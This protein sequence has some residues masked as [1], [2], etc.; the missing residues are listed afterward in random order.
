VAS[1]RKT[2]VTACVIE[3]CDGESWVGGLCAAHHQRQVRHGDPLRGGPVR[4][5]VSG[6]CEAEGCERPKYAKGFCSMHYQRA[7][8]GMAL[9]A[10]RKAQPG[11]GHVGRDGYRYIFRPGHPNASVNGKIAEHRYVMAEHLG[12]PLLPTEQVHHKNGMRQDNRVE[13]LELW[14]RQHPTSMRVDDLVA[15][16]RDI[17]ALYD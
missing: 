3:G 14:S 16:A 9:D 13:N 5:R 6:P 11:D 1:S 15:W 8:R 17:L 2:P 4:R 10:P 12:R 7:K